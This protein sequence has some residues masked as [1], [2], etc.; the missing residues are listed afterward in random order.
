[1]R[2]NSLS[3]NIEGGGQAEDLSLDG[4]IILEWI[5]ETW[6]EE[7]WT[8]LIWLRVGTTD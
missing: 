1:M 8:G 4:R 6:G 7:V 5:L 3:E 2:A